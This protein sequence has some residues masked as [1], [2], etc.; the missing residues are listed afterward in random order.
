[1]QLC[2]Q[3]DKLNTYCFITIST[4]FSESSV[5]Y[6]GFFSNTDDGDSDLKLILLNTDTESVSF[7]MVA[8]GI[9]YAQTGT[10]SAN[11]QKIVDIPSE[12]EVTSIDD[13]AKGIH[14]TVTSDAVTVIGQSINGNNT[15]T[16]TLLPVANLNTD[17]YTY[18]SISTSQVSS[19]DY[20][21]T[22]LVVGTEDNTMLELTATQGVQVKIGDNVDNLV[23]GKMYSFAIIRLQTVYIAAKEDLSG[24]KIVTD[25][26]V[27]VFSGHQNGDIEGWPVRGYLAEQIP[28][29]AYWDKLYYFASTGFNV[30]I[31]ILAAEDGTNVDIHCNGIKESHNI[32]EGKSVEKFLE[33]LETAYCAVHSDKPV[34]V[35]EM[36]AI[37][38]NQPN[39]IGMPMMAT[40]LGTNQFSN[41]LD[42][43]TLNPKDSSKE[44]YHYINLIVLDE[45]YQP[46]MIHLTQG[47]E[48]HTLNTG[49]WRP[50]AADNV[51]EAYGL[52]I[53]IKS[54]PYTITHDNPVA[55]MTVMSFGTG[56]QYGGYGHSGQFR[57]VQGMVYVVI[58]CLH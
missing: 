50:I 34:L 30:I 12:A 33:S 24:T 13:Q 7:T 49:N 57:V 58:L 51:V 10:I 32:N 37:V 28:P 39:F 17:K 25:K 42:S 5:H 8:P 4:V 31:K 2:T 14:L 22:I 26:L 27:S 3:L 43:S 36:G 23:P 35:A 46:D 55:K 47:G 56:E 1:M 15:D 21:N 44:Y 16:F 9:D 11:E 19:Y 53:S 45:Y 54:G 20:Y 40:V 52:Q 38:Y 41:N 6:F 48:T 29:T 18:Y